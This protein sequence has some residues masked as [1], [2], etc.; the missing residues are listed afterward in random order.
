MAENMWEQWPVSK[1]FLT[2]LEGNTK[3]LSI[4]RIGEFNFISFKVLLNRIFIISLNLFLR[5]LN[6][7]RY[8]EVH[9][10]PPVNMFKVNIN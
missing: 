4:L 10:F 1:N 9:S 2:D 3:I 6:L 7:S 8:I 5:F